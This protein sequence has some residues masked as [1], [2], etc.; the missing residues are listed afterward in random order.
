MSI[1]NVDQDVSYFIG[2]FGSGLDHPECITSGLEG[3]A[4]AGGEAGQIY[5]IDTNDRTFEEIANT[6]N[7]VG[8]I[9][10]SGDGDLYVCSGSVMK[11]TQD[12]VLNVYSDG[13]EIDKISSPN[14]PAFDQ[15]GNLFV[16]DSGIWRENNGRI[17]KILPGGHSEI[18]SDQLNDFPNGIC[19]SPLG[20]YLYVAMSINP[21]V[22]RIKINSDGSSGD[23][24][25]VVKLPGTVPD[26]VAFD[27]KG[28]LYISCYRP[29]IIYKFDISGDL[30]VLAIDYLGTMM[31][32]PTNV[33]FCGENLDIFLSANLGR[34]HIS[35]YDLS[36]VGLPLNYPKIS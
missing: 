5:K 6:K 9:A 12:G 18:F 25:T 2:G 28:N 20:D 11:V 1:L 27:I 32:C 29:D 16:S 4:Y 34:W 36:E 3:Y 30:N 26:G 24:E 23:V 14:Y 10:Q 8:G 33:A 13:N 22:C 35:K 19:L 17:F 15:F 21:R 31:A 7:F